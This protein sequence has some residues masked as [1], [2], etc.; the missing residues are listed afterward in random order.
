MVP[1]RL[2]PTSAPRPSLQT[3][4]VSAPMS[5]PLSA[6]LSLSR[7]LGVLLAAFASL[8]ACGPEIQYRVRPGYAT[9]SDLPDEIVLEDGSIIRYV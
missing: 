6:S 7:R 2:A 8:A 3:A 9:S 5:V 1:R 4:S